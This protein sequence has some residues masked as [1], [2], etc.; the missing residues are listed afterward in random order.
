MVLQVP[1]GSLGILDDAHFRFV[2]DLGV[3]GPDRAR[4]ANTCR[5]A[6]LQGRAARGG[7]FRRQDPHYSN[8]VIIRAFVQNGDIAGA[9]PTSRRTR[10]CIRFPRRATRPTEVRELLGHADQH[11][12]R[13]RFHL[14]RGAERGRAARAGR[15]SRTG[16]GGLLASI[17]IKKGKP[18]APD[19]R[20]KA[21]LTDAAAVANATSRA[22]ISPRD[23]RQRIY[24]DRQVD[25]HVHRAFTSSPMAANAAADARTMSFYYVTG[26]IRRR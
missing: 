5:A 26:V 11:R 6:G 8:I 18:F 17:G 24:P 23:P 20:M 16:S 19:A 25:H 14:L 3:P 15:L 13:Q 10:G 1:P 12:P 21:I 2:T 4:A 22:I 7:L 9:V